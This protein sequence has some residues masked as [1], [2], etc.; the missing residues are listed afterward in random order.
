MRGVRVTHQTVHLC[1]V[2][3]D[4][5]HAMGEREHLKLSLI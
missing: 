4:H 1:G 2:S 3:S 5:T